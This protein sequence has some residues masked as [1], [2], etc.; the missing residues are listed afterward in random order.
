MNDDQA[1]RDFVAKYARPYDPESDNY[2]RHRLPQIS[3]KEERSYLQCSL[4][5]HQGSPSSIIPYIL[6]YTARR[7]DPRSVLRIGNDRSGGANVR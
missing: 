4:L 7:P 5:P 3:R 6:H 1:L 2:E